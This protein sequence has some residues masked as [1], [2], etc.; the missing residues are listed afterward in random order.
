M[1]TVPTTEEMERVI[2][3]IFKEFHVRSGGMLLVS[4][5]YQKVVDMGYQMEDFQRGM[6]SLIEKEHVRKEENR[7]FL[8]DSGFQEM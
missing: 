2:L 1:A 5:F 7:F 8:T 3:D 6:G 4:T